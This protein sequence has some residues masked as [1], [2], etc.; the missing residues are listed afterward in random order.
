[1]VGSSYTPYPYES[2]ELSKCSI[3]WGGNLI[4]SMSWSGWDEGGDQ[5]LPLTWRGEKEG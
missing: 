5:A 1:L 4:S 2:W 3:T